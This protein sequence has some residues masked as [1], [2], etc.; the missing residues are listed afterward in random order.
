M[1]KIL[2]LQCVSC[3]KEYKTGDLDYL[4]ASC[5][6]TL[7]INYDYKLIKKRFDY[8]VL[9]RNH[10]YDMWRYT[11]LL[12]VDDNDGIPP[13]KVGWTP[14]YEAKALAAKLGIS[15]LFIKDEGRNPT[16]SIKDRGSAVAVARALELKA[17][18]ITDA[19]SGNASD[20]L[21]CLTAG[22][23]LKTVIFAPANTPQ[24]KLAQLYVYGASV[25]RMRDDYDAAFELCRQASQKYGWYNRA[26]GINPYGREGKKT[27]AF[28]ICEQLQ[29]EAPDKVIAAAGDGT[30]ISG[31][32]KGFTD[33]SKLGIIEKM[34]Q[35]IAVQAEGSAAIKNAF[36]AG[37]AQAGSVKAETIAD[38]ISVNRPRDSA[39]ALQAIKESGGG[40]LTVT[41]GEIISAI[42]EF[43]QVS[44]VFAEPGGA[45]PYAALKKLAAQ[46][47]I[48]KDESVALVIGGN[49]LKDISGVLKAVHIPDALLTPSLDDVARL[50]GVETGEEQ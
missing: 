46:G 26:A 22:T 39:L 21:A 45:A 6:G 31:M 15:K 34:P 3:G 19:S 37:A 30:I 44:G 32:W 2:N 8:D 7:E 38:S 23:N 4:C 50:A 13:L 18:V 27:C 5:G 41:D 40:A 42:A 14:L 35:M 33:F 16:G 47:K 20:S 9:E 48:K 24:A 17:K 12:P 25:I 1:K 49:G 11:D 28:E 10:T 36:D 43:A 29:W